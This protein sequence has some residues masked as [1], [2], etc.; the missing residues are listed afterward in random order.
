MFQAFLIVGREA[1]ELLLVMVALR[2]WARQE[3]RPGLGP[4]M[5][6]GLLGGL[7]GAAVVFAALPATGM[8]EG[9]DLALSGGFGL[10]VA[11]LSCGTMASMG[12]IGEH[13]QSRFDAWWMRRSVAVPVL[14]F[15]A[16]SALREGLEAALL[17]RFVALGT[18][19]HEV[20]WGAALGLL[21]CALLAG[22]WQ[23][24][25]IGRRTRIVFRLTAVLL[26]VLGVQMMLE[27]LAALLVRGVAGAP[28]IRLGQALAPYVEN[29][30]RYW[31]LC[32]ALA[33]IPLLLWMRAWWRQAGG[34]QRR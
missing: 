10:S 20:A 25:A 24:L 14:V 8:S 21:A 7:A 3:E 18:D 34:K 32:A 33:L 31:L 26:F 27:A 29:G 15:V 1:I 2:E 30:D 16:F 11:L 19:L 22:A 12:R 6:A 5:A 4:W 9:F 13:A 28:M 17:I 23:M